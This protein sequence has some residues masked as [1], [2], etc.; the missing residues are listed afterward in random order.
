MSCAPLLFGMVG[1]GAGSF[2]GPVHRLA[3]CMDHQAVLA[4]GALSSDPDRA[5]ASGRELGLPDDRNYATWRDMLD[6]ERTRPVDPDHPGRR[7]DFVSIVTP[8]DSHYEIAR[9]FAEAGFN[10][11]VDK[12]M[13]HTSAQAAELVRIVESAGIVFAVTY[14]YTGYPMVKQAAAMVR[15][16]VLG[17]IRKVFVEYHQGWLATKLEDAGVKQAAWRTDPSRAGTAGSLADIGSHAENLLSTITGLEID[18]LCADLTSFVR[19][20]KLDDDASVLIRFKGGAKAVLT[21]SQVCIGEANNLS[22]RIHGS[23]GSLAWRQE[24]PDVLIHA[25]GVGEHAEM[26]ILRRGSPSR[27]IVPAAALATRIPEGHPEGY[28]EAFANV[29]RSA[30]AAMRSRNASTRSHALRSALASDYPTVYDGARGVRFIE[31]VV[32]SAKR[33]SAWIGF[34]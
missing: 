11:V 4:A 26:R 1:G 18:A 3:A 13:V 8:N 20:R 32:E 19:G 30:I 9:A 16:G 29:Y 25:L 14:N 6:R 7:I 31:K 5:R 33:N 2:I 17:D 12:P 23:E 15:A 28:L 22:I 24:N 27:A 10:V 21:C 34:A